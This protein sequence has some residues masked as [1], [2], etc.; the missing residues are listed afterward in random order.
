MSSKH[1]QSGTEPSFLPQGLLLPVL[2]LTEQ[3]WT[4]FAP[5]VASRGG[6]TIPFSKKSFPKDISF[7]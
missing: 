5:D 1:D 7:L 3:T 6:L 4:W 2:L